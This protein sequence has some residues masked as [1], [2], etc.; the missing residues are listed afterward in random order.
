MPHYTAHTFSSDW[1]RVPPWYP[2]FGTLRYLSPILGALMATTSTAT[3]FT[4]NDPNK[5][6]FLYYSKCARITTKKLF[7]T[8]TAEM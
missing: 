5:P 4:S 2:A 7:I 6:I 8:L 3:K 1:D